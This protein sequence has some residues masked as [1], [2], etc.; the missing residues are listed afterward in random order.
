MDDNAREVASARTRKTGWLTFSGRVRRR[1]YWWKLFLLM[2]VTVGLI[3]TASTLEV[4]AKVIYRITVP[5][6]VRLMFA[7]ALILVTLVCNVFY[8]PVAVRRLH[9]CDLS[10][11]WCL[12]CFSPCLVPD[13]PI[14]N[15]LSI[16]IIFIIGCMDGTC[17]PNRFGPDPKGRE[18]SDLPRFRLQKLPIGGRMCET[19]SGGGLPV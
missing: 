18:P 7:V 16:A 13:V 10:G 14:R 8:I 11:W 9:D 15:V 12:L 19:E 17:G 3:I 2:S 4:V 1:E 6:D 5:S